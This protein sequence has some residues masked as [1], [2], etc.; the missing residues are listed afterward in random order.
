MKRE[1]YITI[2]LF[3]L[4]L[5]V[6]AMTVV[7]AQSTDDG[8]TEKASQ[9]IMKECQIKKNPT[10]CEGV[11]VSPFIPILHVLRDKKA[12]GT[13]VDVSALSIKMFETG[14]AGCELERPIV[15][16][17]APFTRQN[18]SISISCS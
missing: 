18:L 16:R 14:F 9:A 5:F 10:L 2:L 7:R 11:N 1:I 15:V 17:A 12:T 8:Q 6:L 3:A 13:N 4:M